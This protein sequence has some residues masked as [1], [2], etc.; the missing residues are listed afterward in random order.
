M[1]GGLDVMAH[2]KGASAPASSEQILSQIR[3]LLDQY[4]ALGPDTPVAAEAQ[5]LASAI[6]SQTGA[7]TA[8]G[9]PSPEGPSPTGGALAMNTPEP[10]E[11]T[12]AEEVTPDDLAGEDSTAQGDGYKK[13]RPGAKAF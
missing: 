9:A 13:K 1:A 2:L 4:L 3:G 6:D 8:A 5:G 11:G 10:G 12:P 7:G